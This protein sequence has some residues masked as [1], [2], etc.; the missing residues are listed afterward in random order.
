ME[1]AYGAF[2]RTIPL[3]RNVDM[4]NAEASYKNGVL[5]IRLPKVDAKTAGLFR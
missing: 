2:Q 3:P 5:N 1:R 4:D